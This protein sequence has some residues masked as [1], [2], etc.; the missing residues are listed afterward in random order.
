MP[1]AVDCGCCTVVVHSGP[2]ALLCLPRSPTSDQRQADQ[3]VRRVLPRR[4][5]A[6]RT[7]A[8][9]SSSFPPDRHENCAQNEIPPPLS[10][11]MSTRQRV[12]LFVCRWRRCARRTRTLANGWRNMCDALAPA[13]RPR[14]LG[15]VTF[16]LLTF[17]GTREVSQGTRLT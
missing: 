14:I 16:S 13:Q 9:A 1:Q 17:S 15:R 10:S 6:R 7:D 4:C 2:S 3:H 12:L 11:S 5:P 8:G